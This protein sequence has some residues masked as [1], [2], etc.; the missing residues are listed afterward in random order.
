MK[1]DAGQQTRANLVHHAVALVA[2]AGLRGLTYRQLAS[3]AG[4]SHALITYYFPSKSELVDDVAEAASAMSVEAVA[5]HSSKLVGREQ[6]GLPFLSEKTSLAWAEIVI[7]AV[8]SEERR[9]MVRDWIKRVSALAPSSAPWNGGQPTVTGPAYAD[10]TLGLIFIY[11]ATGL[12]ADSFQRLLLGD[13]TELTERACAVDPEIAPSLRSGRKALVTR[14]AIIEAAQRIFLEGGAAAVT[15]KAIAQAGGLSL[16]TP[17]YHF[18]S[19]DQVF[20]QL[21]ATLAEASK[22]RYR[23]VMRQAGT[24]M[25]S[26]DGLVEV[27]A[28]VLI[29]E[30]TESSQ[31][32][33]A[34]FSTWL[35]APRQAHRA[36]I[37]PGFVLNQLV[38]WDRALESSITN[39]A[40]EPTSSLLAMTLFTGKLVRLLAT[41]SDLSDLSHIRTELSRDFQ[42][43][44][45]IASP[46]PKVETQ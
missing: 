24:A 16:T 33:L 3:R 39:D 9:P 34:F 12:S 28:A 36:P 22:E 6:L 35:E 5:L 21:L 17:A 30:A 20:R 26:F 7:D 4:V 10:V 42:S 37:L 27:T 44:A 14:A 38:A 23:S 15:H 41:G 13:R 40:A 1:L 25:T 2:E 29:R 45:S 19:I 8:R 31:D 43:V 11:F 46:I 32:N 18:S